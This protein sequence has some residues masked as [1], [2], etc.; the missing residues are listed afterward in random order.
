LGSGRDHARVRTIRRNGPGRGN[1]NVV[2][3]EAPQERFS[4]LTS[5]GIVPAH[6]EHERFHRYFP[7]PGDVPRRV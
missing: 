1:L 5:A 3:G 4:N 7:S 2:T 6:E